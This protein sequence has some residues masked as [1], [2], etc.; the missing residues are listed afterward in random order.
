MDAMKNEMECMATN[1]V[2]DLIDLPKGCKA[3]DYKWVFKTKKYFKRKVNDLRPNLL[4]RVSLKRRVSTTMKPSPSIKE[5]FIQ[6]Y[7]GTYS[8]L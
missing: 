2:S 1:N 4:P 7:H 5:G 6:N 8:T 3:V